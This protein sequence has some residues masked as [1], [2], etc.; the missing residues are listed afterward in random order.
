MFFKQY[1]AA[2]LFGQQMQFDWLRRREFIT[3]FGGA[4][5]WPIEARAQQPAMPVV[6]FLESRRLDA[7]VD[8]LRGFHRGLKDAGF[9]EGDNVA[10]VY[11]WAE[12]QIDRLPELANELVRRRVAVIAMGGGLPVVLAATA[13]TKTIPI[14]A[15]FAEDPTKIGIVASLARPGGNVTGVNF[16]TAELVTKQLQLLHELVPQATRLVVLVNPANP[17]SQTTLKDMEAAAR[18]IGIHIQSVPVGTGAEIDM[19]FAGFASER[20]DALFV[21]V[22]PFFN[23]RRVQFAQWT[24]HHRI[25]AVYAAREFPEAGGLMSYG[26]DIANAYHQVGVYT[27]R[28]LKGAKP[29]ELPVVQSTKL[30]LVINRQTAKI[31]GLEVPPT[32]LAHADEVIE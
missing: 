24:A 5:A 20:P 32:L 23:S 3:L 16:L 10:I 11:R 28:I 25:P 12:N 22:D 2:K 31:L 29:A 13:A 9:V 27:G 26:S 18:A 7:V 6:G 30:E 14:V 15:T 1:A 17:T 19:A 4:A 21:P 8:R